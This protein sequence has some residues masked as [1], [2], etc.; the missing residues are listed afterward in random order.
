MFKWRAESNRCNC[1][2]C[3]QLLWACRNRPMSRPGDVGELLSRQHLLGGHH[4]RRGEPLLPG[5][6]HRPLSASRCAHSRQVSPASGLLL[7]ISPNSYFS[8]PSTWKLYFSPFGQTPIFVPHRPLRLYFSFLQLL[9]YN[10][11]ISFL[12]VFHLFLF[13]ILYPFG[14]FLF[15]S[16]K[17]HRFFFP[18]SWGGD[19]SICLDTFKLRV[20]ITVKKRFLTCTHMCFENLIDCQ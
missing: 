12:C 2:V 16:S 11:S 8:L 18:P 9:Y 13:V 1:Q 14:L 7:C 6:A 15:F 17:W 10:I 5:H 3:I 19:F 4:P 20:I